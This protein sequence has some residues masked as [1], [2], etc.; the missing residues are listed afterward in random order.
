MLLETIEK[1]LLIIGAS[2]AHVY[3]MKVCVVEN[4]DPLLLSKIDRVP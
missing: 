4:I 3:Q 2:L 1:A